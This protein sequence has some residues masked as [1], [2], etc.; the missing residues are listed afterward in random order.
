MR[1]LILKCSARKRGPAEPIAVVDRYDG[2]LWQV[3]RSYLRE[4]PMFVADLTI[5]GLSAEYGLIPGDHRIPHYDA[6][7]DAD[8]AEVLRPQVLATLRQIVTPDC[9]QLCLGI[10][11]RYLRALAG[12]EALIPKGVE[13]TLTDGTMG[14]KLGQL[15]AWLEGRA[16]TPPSANRPAR[17]TAPQKPRGEVVLSGVPIRMSREEILTA[18]RTALQAGATGAER[19]RDWYVLVDDRRVSAKWLA[20]LISG[21]PPSAFDTGNACRALLALGVDV[22]RNV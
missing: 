2:P 20:G 18:A 19:F 4:Q 16:W 21:L 9:R 11:Q 10:S 1:L 5:Y 22:E 12:W 14:E 15:R 17:L 7:M 13:V 6:T 8:R 3:L